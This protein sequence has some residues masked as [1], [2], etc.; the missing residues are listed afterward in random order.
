MDDQHLL[1]Q[2]QSRGDHHH[3]PDERPNY[4]TILL[5]RQISSTSLDRITPS[6]QQC[7]SASAAPIV[8]EEEE[9]TT[10]TKYSSSLINLLANLKNK[11]TKI[12]KKSHSAP[13]VILTQ[14]GRSGPAAAASSSS[15]DDTPNRPQP[16]PSLVRQALISVAIYLLIGFTMFT[17]Q[18]RS[19]FKVETTSRAVDG[20]YFSIVTLCTIGYGDIVPDT[21]F[22]KLVMCG[23]ILVGFGCTDI[24]LNGLV[25]YVLDT[26]EAVLLG[27][28]VDHHNYNNKNA[29]SLMMMMSYMVDAKKGRMRVRMKVGLALAVVVGCIA[30][31]AISAHV[32]EKLDW[33]DSFYLSVSSVTTVGYGDYAFSTLQ[34]RCFASVWLLVST[35]AVARAF[36][37]LTEL[38]IERRNRKVA[39]WVLQRRMTLPDLVAADLDNNGSVRYVTSLINNNIDH[40]HH[41]HHLLLNSLIFL[42]SHIYT[43]KSMRQDQYGCGG[44]WCMD[45]VEVNLEVYLAT[46]LD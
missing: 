32:L 1:S 41:H 38:R 16:I 21:T 31:G 44:D 5:L 46:A 22:T 18:G 35:L 27:A 23:L 9:A 29:A 33:V 26:Q 42:K 39:N 19:G 30:I 4:S 7:R 24:L 6:W 40:H 3:H 45:P 25:T 43:Y 17:T 34:G 15:I 28:V 20:L 13:S 8:V 37:Y 11:T 36:L 2:S 14:S 10:T 12:I